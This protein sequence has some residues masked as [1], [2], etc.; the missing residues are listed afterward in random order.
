M[1]TRVTR[2]Q[3]SNKSDYGHRSYHWVVGCNY[4]PNIGIIRPTQ[5]SEPFRKPRETI[6]NL[7]RSV[8]LQTRGGQFGREV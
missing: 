5:N 8:K 2:I 4:E 6:H 1:D 3:H 7:L